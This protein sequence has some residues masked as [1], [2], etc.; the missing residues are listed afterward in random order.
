MKK[1]SIDQL[2]NFQ[3]EHSLGQITWRSNDLRFILNLTLNK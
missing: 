2:A 3:I 1:I